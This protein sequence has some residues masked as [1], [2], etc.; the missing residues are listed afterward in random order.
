MSRI[1][2]FK[3]SLSLSKSSD[4]GGN[5]IK[6]DVNTNITSSY[7]V[8]HPNQQGKDGYTMKNDSGTLN[9]KNNT[10][11]A[12]LAKLMY[13]PFAVGG[14]DTSS[15][16]G[17]GA[18]WRSN[19]L[20]PNGKI[21]NIPI[22]GSS[23]LII[24]TLTDTIDTTTL[25]NISNSSW[26]GAILAPNGKIYCIP[27]SSVSILIIDPETDTYET[28]GNLTGSSK[29]LGGCLAPNGKI[30]CTPY[31][32]ASILIIDTSD[33]STTT[34]GSLTTDNGKWGGACLGPNGKIYMAGTARTNF[35]II[36]P[37]DNSFDTSAIINTGGECQGMCLG[38]N[39]KL[40]CTSRSR[41]TTLV[42]NPESPYDTTTIAHG[43]GSV[44]AFVGGGALAPNG[45]IYI[46]P[47]NSTNV[48]IV[49][50]VT[51]TADNAS[52]SGLS[53]T[54][55]FTSAIVAP[56]GC[57]YMFPWTI[58]YLL[59]IFPGGEQTIP[60]QRCISAYYNKL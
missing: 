16:T 17:V 13:N 32:S 36:D 30:Y 49:N 55:K 43:G 34:I 33:N 23:I 54:N 37:S 58:T 28:V 3:G 35:I 52:I 27:F 21:Y 6:Q 42:V 11:N 2:D 10:T 59:K 12:N 44:N 56:N 46:P 51:N 60:I 41:S 18:D 7:T 22:T 15:I 5:E 9:W 53:G 4:I 29:W 19:C 39:G 40:Y 47:R 31:A 57:I 1:V 48:T 25:S 14:Y 38:P 45:K 8:T 50:P 24:D 26:Y 20:A